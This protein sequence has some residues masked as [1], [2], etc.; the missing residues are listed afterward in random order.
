MYSAIP[1]LIMNTKTQNQSRVNLDELVEQHYEPVFRFA[2]S[3]SGSPEAA[4]DLTRQ[5]FCLAL[6]NQGRLQQRAKV[7]SWLLTLVYRACARF[8]GETESRSRQ[9]RAFR[10][11][12]NGEKQ[13]SASKCRSGFGS[14]SGRR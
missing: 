10:S 3:L 1:T 6:I 2:S 4:S 9:R 8:R 12:P 14:K 5:A 7:R 13:A 11:S